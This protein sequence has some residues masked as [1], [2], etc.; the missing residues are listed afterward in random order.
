MPLLNE[1]RT[2]TLSRTP[3]RTVEALV[4]V[5]GIDVRAGGGGLH[6]ERQVPVAVVVRESG[7]ERRRG[8]VPQ[9]GI[10]MAAI[11]MATPIVAGAIVRR[12]KTK[13]RK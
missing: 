5:R 2:V 4:R 12:F 13:R 8:I 11:A 7:E 3:H 10:G 1:T 9:P 6:I